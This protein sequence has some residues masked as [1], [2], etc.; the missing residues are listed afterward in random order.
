MLAT[1]ATTIA[2]TTRAARLG[3]RSPDRARHQ[4]HRDDGAGR[5]LPLL[6]ARPTLVLQTIRLEGQQPVARRN[7]RGRARRPHADWLPQAA[8]AAPR[9]PDRAPEHSPD[10]ARLVLSDHPRSWAPY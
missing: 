9:A 1:R 6:R 7:R 5:L 8:R 10:R 4:M 3:S 2:A